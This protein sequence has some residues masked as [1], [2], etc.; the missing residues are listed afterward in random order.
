MKRLVAIA[1]LALFSGLSTAT[2]STTPTVAFARLSPAVV[3]G[4]GFTPRSAVRVHVTWRHGALTKTVRTTS[5]GDVH[6]S[7]GVVDRDLPLPGPRGRRRHSRR[8]PRD[9]EACGRPEDV[10]RDRRS[11]ILNS[12]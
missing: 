8:P 1:C 5:R 2:A 7:L 6:G 11:R 9:R 10:R 3:K 12:T 4:Q